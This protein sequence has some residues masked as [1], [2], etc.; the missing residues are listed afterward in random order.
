M[1]LNQL[2]VCCSAFTVSFS[3]MVDLKGLFFKQTCF[4]LL[5]ARIFAHVG[6]FVIKVKKF[7]FDSQELEWYKRRAEISALY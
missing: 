6:T 1:V 5:C 2:F 3:A 4:M 7:Y